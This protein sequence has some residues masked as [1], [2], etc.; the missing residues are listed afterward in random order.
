MNFAEA[1]KLPET[2]NTPVVEA[3]A[4]PVVEAPAA[5][6]TPDAPAAPP[7]EI[8]QSQAPNIPAAPDAAPA[9]PAAPAFDPNKIL[10]EMS[11]GLFKDKAAFEAALPKLKEYEGL[12]AKHDELA[13]AMAL[14]PVFANDHVRIYNDL[15]KN[16]AT[17]EQLQNF[18]KINEVGDINQLSP[19]DA[20]VAKMVL[21]DGIKE[22][23]AQKMVNREYKVGD[24]DLDADDR[25]ILDEQLR[26]SSQADKQALAQFKAAVSDVNTIKP[27]EL[28]LQQTAQLQAHQAQVRPYAKDVADTI[29]TMGKF[30]LGASDP[31]KAVEI[32]LP[33][34][35]D[36]K[37]K[38]AQYLENYYMDGLTPV[39]PENTRL[40]MDYGRAEYIRENLPAMLEKVY[41]ILDNKIT[42][43]MVAKY[44]NRSGV[45]SPADNPIIPANEAAETANWMANRVNRVTA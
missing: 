41:E 24:E 28:Q 29:T 2:P 34:A 5:V 36:F 37:P 3:P 13:A 30:T 18:Q 39:T 1:L 32:E 23:V 33:V 9:A 45:K 10:D 38:M 31:A 14:A 12:K 19:I 15:V 42:E 6:I 17:K 20:K 22:S 40:A 11:G 8:P 4:A 27:E 25:E 35:E 21:V 7:A 43:R 44:E 26:V 16:G